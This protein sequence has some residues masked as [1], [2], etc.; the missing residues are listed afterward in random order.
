MRTLIG[1]RA[2]AQAGIA[3]TVLALAA[4]ALFGN[5][6]TQTA[7][8]TPESLVWLRTNR[9]QAVRVNPDTRRTV[10]R[11]PVGGVGDQLEVVQ[12]KGSLIITNRS[13]RTVTIVDLPLMRVSGVRQASADVKVLLAERR[14]FLVDRVAGEVAAIDPL[15]AKT[16]GRPYQAGGAILDAAVDSDALW[17]LGEGGRLVALNWSADA[18]AERERRTLPDITPGAVVTGHVRGVTV[19][20]PNGKVVRIGSNQDRTLR[21]T[22]LPGPLLGA[23]RTPADLAPITSATSS[24][25]RIV[26]SDGVTEADGKTFGCARVGR[27]AVY[28]NLIYIPCPKARK[29]IVLDP[30]GRR[31]GPDVAT[32]AGEDLELVPTAGLLIVNVLGAPKGLVIKPDGSIVEIQTDDPRVPVTNPSARPTALP[33]GLGLRK[34]QTSPTAKRGQ[35]ARTP[36]ASGQSRAPVASPGGRSPSSGPI[37]STTP[38]PTPGPTGSE[39]PLPTQGPTQGPPSSAPPSSRAPRPAD[40]TPTAVTATARP[41][42]TI[43]VS[44]TP[45]PNLP[46]S[47][48]IQRTD[49]GAQVGTAPS[50]ATFTYIGGLPLG[51]PVSFVVVAVTA[52]TSYP[53]APSN[54]VSAYGRPGEPAIGVELAALSPTRVT[55]RITVDVQS[56]GGQPVTTYDLEVKSDRDRTLVSVQ[57]VPIGQRPYQFTADCVTPDDVCMRGGSVT[58]TASL[59]NSAGAGPPGRASAGIPGPPG[60]VYGQGFMYVS[61]GGKCLDGDLKLHT[62]SG[63]A[64]QYWR[65]MN[66]GDIRNNASNLCL[67][68]NDSLHL[69]SSGCSER[70]K[71]WK[72]VNEV[73]N[74]AQIRGQYDGQECLYVTG[75]PAGEGVPVTDSHSCFNGPN[76]RWTAWRQDSVPMSAFAPAAAAAAPPPSGS[77]VPEIVLLLLAPLTL[78]LLRRRRVARP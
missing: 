40:F 74:E 76:E 64:S 12:D 35:T 45:P 71:R 41:D 37:G 13:T 9:G 28:R 18:F 65:H 54:A 17:V 52:G 51:Q 14:I 42:G 62:C 10:E 5:G 72:R 6:L 44:W 29:V 16:I 70:P 38:T 26:R 34:P 39:S 56:D 21:A 60:F 30:A 1:R 15:T 57:G 78:G 31:G 77:G 55:L 4:G 73:G 68:Y 20:A 48:Q 36:G 19:F 25:I 67:A 32:P 69:S 2:A 63:I 58:A 24:A 50:G 23:D 7:L 66:T 11:L 59:T 22:G 27:A 43:Q 49:T 8:E 47:Y 61:S 53:S 46:V 75:D 3:A 33:S